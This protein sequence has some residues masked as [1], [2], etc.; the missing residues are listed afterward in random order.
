MPVYPPTPEFSAADKRLLLLM[1]KLALESLAHHAAGRNLPSDRVS[2]TNDEAAELVASLEQFVNSREFLEAA[3]FVEGITSPD[4]H[5]EK[6]T[7]EIY[8]SVRKRK[9]RSRALA[10]THWAEFRIRLGMSNQGARNAR[11]MP[12]EF[13]YFRHMER[14]LLLA[15]GIDPRV[16][17]LADRLI[18]KK[19]SELE[20][21]RS[22]QLAIGRGN[23][24]RTVAGPIKDGRING[25]GIL[26]Q[27]ISTLRVLASIQ[28][29]TDISVLFTTRDWSV[30]GTLSTMSGALAGSMLD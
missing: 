24:K 7:R 22:G 21:M 10:S 2:L 26:D 14:D 12:M 8:L 4:P 6:R 18:L 13:D 28:I 30:A 17:D 29:V 16:V 23:L 3:S 19:R 11:A 27:G 15:A 25:A 20:Q 5:E 9:G 1:S